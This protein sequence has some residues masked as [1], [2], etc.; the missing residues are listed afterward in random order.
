[1]TG[2]EEAM[3]DIE[4]QERDRQ[5]HEGLDDQQRFGDDQNDY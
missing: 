1:M 5:Y 4:A 2:T 3:Q